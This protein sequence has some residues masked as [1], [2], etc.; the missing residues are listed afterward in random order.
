RSS[1]RPWPPPAPRSPPRAVHPAAGGAGALP[2]VLVP[3]TDL[4][5]P[6]LRVLH[7]A[8]VGPAGAS[9]VRPADRPRATARTRATGLGPWFPPGAWCRSVRPPLRSPACASA[10]APADRG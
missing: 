7:P 8:W 2:P 3:P 6:F 4:A 10:P 9:P 1:R 5:G